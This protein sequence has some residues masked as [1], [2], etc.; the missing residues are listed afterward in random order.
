MD[1]ITLNKLLSVAD[2]IE[3]ERTGNQISLDTLY[4]IVDSLGKIKRLKRRVRDILRVLNEAKWLKQSSHNPNLLYV[5]EDF[6]E[7]MLAWD[8]EN[9]LLRMNQ[10]LE[11]YRPYKEFLQCLRGEEKIPIPRRQDSIARRQLGERLARHKITYVAFDT[12]RAWAVSLGYAYLAPSDRTLYWGGNWVT[13]SLTLESFRTAC[14]E[15]YR[16]T[17]KTSGFANLGQVADLVCIR[18]RISFQAFEMQ[19]NQFIENCPG[20]VKLAPATIRRELS[21]Y[22][23]ISSVRPRSEI[24]R[25]RLIAELQGEAQQTHWLEHRFLEDG[26]RVKGNLVKLIRW[27]VTT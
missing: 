25:E 10:C 7:F 3:R 11:S 2:G 27:E 20:E 26:I 15:G 16:Q 24:T 8:S 23:R 17:S 14:L 4:A 18:L 1:P 19:M 5:H 12:F 22:S 6:D 13:Q 21:G 9:H